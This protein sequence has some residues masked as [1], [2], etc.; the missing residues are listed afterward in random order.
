M[1]PLKQL[2]TRVVALL[3]VLGVLL[4]GGALPATAAPAAPATP[5]APPT[6]A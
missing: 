4:F 6:A 3:V 5:T 2:G 1:R